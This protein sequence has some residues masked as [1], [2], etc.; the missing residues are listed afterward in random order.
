MEES[1]ISI[2]TAFVILSAASPLLDVNDTIDRGATAVYTVSL[3]NDT[4]YWVT[5]ESVEEQTNLDVTAASSEMDFEHF[6][7]LPYGEDFV[8]A[9]DFAVVSG[10]EPGN[11]SITLPAENSSLVYLIV[12]DTGGNGGQFTLKIQ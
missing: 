3:D 4:V 1:M 5:L 12:H 7:N 10:I 11:E 2:C 6:M 9:L 8:Y